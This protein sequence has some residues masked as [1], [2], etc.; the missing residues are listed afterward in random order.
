MT[1]CLAVIGPPQ[2]GKSEVTNRIAG[3]EGG[4]APA[5]SPDDL[6]CVEFSYLEERWVAL[7][8]PGS[9][10]FAQSAQDALLCADAAV[11][12]ASPDPDQAVL[13]APWIRIAERCQ[14][15]HLLL[16]NRMDE[17]RATAR[18]I[19]SALQAY[20]AQPIILRQIPIRD[21]ERILGAVDLVSERAWR[22]RPDAPSELVEI[23]A[24]LRQREAEGRDELLESLSELDDWLLEEIIEDRT[25][26]SGAIY[27]ICARTLAGNEA[28]PAFLGSAVQGAGMHRLMKA[29]RHESPAPADTGKRLGGVDAAV[30]MARTR[31]HVG[32]LAWLRNFG[33]ELKIGSPLGGGALG[34]L[35]EPGGERPAATPAVATGGIVSAVK[36]DHLAPGNLYRADAVADRP[37][38]Y[39]PL[40]PLWRR[41]L[42]AANDREDV[43][44][45]ESLQKIAAEDLSLVVDHDQESGQIVVGT[46]GA[47]H[48]RRVQRT[49]G[50]VFGVETVAAGVS[51]SYQETLTRQAEIHYRHKKQSGGAGQFADVKMTVAPATRGDGFAFTA[52]IHGGSV[53]RNYIPAVEHGAREALTRGPLGFPVVDVRVNLH[54]GQHHA[55]D[56]SDMAFRIAGR[57]AVSEGLKEGEPVLLEPIYEVRFQA[58]SVFTGALN[59]MIS[60]LRG[61]ILGFDREVEAEGWDMV[62]ALM[63]GAALEDLIN[64]L[65]SA[66]QGVGRYE[67]ELSVY[68]E[69]YGRE[70]QDIVARRAEEGGRR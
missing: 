60:S 41:T 14:V 61:Q 21:G 62:R 52:S 64:H 48:L 12:V 59:P 44:L 3:L 68:Q 33:A 26:A 39:Q 27:G 2:I 46:Q 5:G 30:F 16:L 19:I 15:P 69:L 7:D 49:L 40:P 53:P 29:L 28:V 25:P 43:K 8:C 24:E 56:S 66:T 35:V 36:S 47:Q 70:A 50:E 57:G 23:P 13:A 18:E 38:W 65:R 10:E 54:D 58:P 37:D 11:I 6:R 17:C 67:A 45:S 20:S 1:R 63:P 51:A 55:V 42:A 4:R 31:K 22:Y 34:G 32:R 9:L